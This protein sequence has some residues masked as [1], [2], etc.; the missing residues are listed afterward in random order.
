MAEEQAGSK[1]TVSILSNELRDV[2]HFGDL[3]FIEED[4]GNFSKPSYQEA[5]GAP[6][7]CHSPLGLEVGTI[8]TILINVS[9]Y[10]LALDDFV[11][12]FLLTVNR[13]IGTGVFSTRKS[14]RF[15]AIHEIQSTFLT[16]IAASILTNVGSVG[17]SMIY[18]VLGALIG[19]C[20]LAVYLEFASYFPNR[21][22]SEVVYLEQSFPRPRYLWA[23]T[24]AV[25]AVVLSF[26]SS[27]CIGMPSVRFAV[28]LM[29]RC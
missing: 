19:C 10:V 16:C 13:M 22:G 2:K 29:C 6:V 8:T 25:Q 26:S 18:W 7:E 15:M 4:G 20:Q 21:S 23:T 11:L 27:N 12:N 14:A 1:A 17:L 5:Y 28:R 24:F 9:M 3:T